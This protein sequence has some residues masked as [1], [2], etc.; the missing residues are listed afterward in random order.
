MLA[1]AR[2]RGQG[3][4]G[5]GLGQPT[6]ILWFSLKILEASLSACFCR[7]LADLELSESSRV[8]PVAAACSSA[9][10]KMSAKV[11]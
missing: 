5:E 11:E 9:V 2:G 1:G 7:V 3:G 8:S 10:V 6:C 4:D